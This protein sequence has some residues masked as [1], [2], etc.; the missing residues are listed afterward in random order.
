MVYY[1]KKLIDDL[2]HIYFNH[3]TGLQSMNEMP[4]VRKVGKIFI[5]TVGRIVHAVD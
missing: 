3:K 2:E 1:E 4:C 5:Y